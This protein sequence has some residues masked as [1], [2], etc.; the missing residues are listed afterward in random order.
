MQSETGWQIGITLRLPSRLPEGQ[1][2]HAYKP[3]RTLVREFMR[4]HQVEV[5]FI[6]V[7]SPSSNPHIH[8]AITYRN[9]NGLTPRISDFTKWE[10]RWNELVRFQN[11]GFVAVPIWDSEGWF[12]YVKKHFLYPDTITFW[13]NKKMLK[14]LGL[15]D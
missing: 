13:R 4:E 12:S 6:G 8:L 3:L 2:P 14:E 10:R 11:G 15:G 5:A 1:E 7:Y 9:H